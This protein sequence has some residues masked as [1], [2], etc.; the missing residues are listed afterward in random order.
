MKTLSMAPGFAF[1]RFKQV[2]TRFLII[3]KKS[4]SLAFGGV[5]IGLYALWLFLVTFTGGSGYESTK[6]IFAASVMIY[7]F[8]GP[9]LTSAIFSDLQSK[10]SASQMLTLPATSTEKLC[11]AW[12]VSYLMFTLASFLAILLI[13]ALTAV[14]ADILLGDMSAGTVDVQVHDFITFAMTYLV[15]NSIFL[16]G[17]VYFR[18]KNFLKTVLAIVLFVFGFGVIAI[19]ILNMTGVGS[20][21]LSLS[22]PLFFFSNNPFLVLLSHLLTYV[23]IAALFLFFSYRSLKNREVV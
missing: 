9:F 4:Y 19:A 8:G 14:S 23:P 6:F 10:N 16:L 5:I 11:S 13:L 3:N 22:P 7:H 18:G 15:Y 20:S 2:T 12:T 17:S 21:Q 1:D